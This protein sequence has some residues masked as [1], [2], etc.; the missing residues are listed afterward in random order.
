MKAKDYTKIANEYAND[1]ISGKETAGAEIVLA[2]KRYKKDLK[3]KDIELRPHDPNMA[4]SIMEGFFVH[5]QGEDMNGKPLLGEPFLLQRW[6]IFIT[7][8]LLGWYYK[9][10]EIRRF[11]EAFIMMAR[12]NGKTSYSAALSFAVGILQRKSGSEQYIVAN[13]LKQTLQSFNFLKFNRITRKDII[14]K[15]P[16]NLA[17]RQCRLRYHFR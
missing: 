2:C 3:R 5:A 16:F 17:A 10:T 11:T 6:E 12:K 4:C 7:V 15:S 14:F 9:G 8:N 1:V 13:S